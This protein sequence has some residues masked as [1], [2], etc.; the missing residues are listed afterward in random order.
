VKKSRAERKEDMHGLFT[1]GVQRAKT[2]GPAPRNRWRFAQKDHRPTA[3]ETKIMSG[4]R[5][6]FIGE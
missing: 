6:I 5:T 2:F 3:V 4:N 1:V